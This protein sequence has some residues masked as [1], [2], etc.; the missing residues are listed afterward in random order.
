[1]LVCLLSRTEALRLERDGVRPTC[2]HHQHLTHNDAKMNVMDG[3]MRWAGDG[4]RGVTDTPNYVWVTV[5]AGW[6]MQDS[7]GS[8]ASHFTRSKMPNPESN[9]RRGVQSF[10]A[11]DYHDNR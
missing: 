3:L 9:A 10:M 7:Y 5:K 2:Q 11:T 4:E 1:M 8:S 6:Q